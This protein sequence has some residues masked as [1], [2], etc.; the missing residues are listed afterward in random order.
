VDFL[1]KLD[2]EFETAIIGQ[3]SPA[4]KEA[5]AHKK[6]TSDMTPANAKRVRNEILHHVYGKKK[7]IILSA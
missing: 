5:V 3:L 7:I 1:V 4:S 6:D 2:Q